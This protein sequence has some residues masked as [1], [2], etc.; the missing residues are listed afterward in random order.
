MEIDGVPDTLPILIEEVYSPAEQL[1]NTVLS[2]LNSIGNN[3]G[4]T[5]KAVQD[6][7]K[8][9]WVFRGFF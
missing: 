4:S 2:S 3:D 8:Y 6:L 5:L 7:S 9:H 1:P